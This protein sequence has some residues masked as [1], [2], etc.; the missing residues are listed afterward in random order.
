MKKALKFLAVFMVIGLAFAACKK[1]A[2]VDQ[3]NVQNVQNV[4]Q[5]LHE[6]GLN[7]LTEEEY[8][9]IPQVKTPSLLK[10]LPTSVD[11]NHSP[12]GDQGGEGSCVAWG[13]TYAG[14]SAMWVKDHPG[15]W[16]QSANIFSPEYVYNQIKASKSCGSGAYV[17]DGLK[18]L[19]S[20]GVCT[21][22]SM[23][24][25]DKTCSTLPTTAQKT[26]AAGFKI[27]SYGTVAIN[28]T[29]IKTQLAAGNPVVVG[30]SV[31]M[32]FEYLAS[33]AVLGAFKKPS[34]GGHCYCVVGY[35]DAK[36]AFKFQ[37][38][39]GTSWASAGFGW[40]NYNNIKSWWTEAY[41]MVN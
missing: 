3:Q 28:A 34:L 32:A 23:P 38:S 22:T 16:S 9:K 29:T 12:V 18:L 6:L 26:E 14:R 36:N 5:P 33:G 25:T 40:I 15:S 1:D 7:F 17:T 4:Q 41:V 27:K 37:N 30:G 11:L 35:D 31:N 2:P 20:Q 21:W 19:V 8:A 10:T 39:W 13:T 24:Y